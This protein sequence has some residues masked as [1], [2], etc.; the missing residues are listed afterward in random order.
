MN[1]CKLLLFLRVAALCSADRKPKYYDD[2]VESFPSL[3][4]KCIAITGTSTGLGYW[5]AVATAKK[6]PACLIMLNRPSKNAD[7]VQ[8]ELTKAAPN[9]T[10]ITVHFD[11]ASFASVRHAADRVNEVAK[12][13]SGLDV[14]AINAG[15]MMQP[16]V[17][18]G[19]GFDV[20][21][22]VNHLG[23]F[24][25][26]KLLMPSFH[27]AVEAGREVRHVTHTSAFRGS[28]AVG[29]KPFNLTYYE[30]LAP[31]TFG[32]NATHADLERY[33]QSKLANMLF[34]LQLYSKFSLD[35]RYSKFKALSAAP[36]F[37]TGT[38]LTIPEP[39]KT[40]M[41]HFALTPQDG[42]CSLLTAMFAPTA[43]SGDFY[44]PADAVI[45]PPYKFMSKGVASYSSF[46]RHLLGLD[47]KY[48]DQTKALM[49]SASE[50]AMGE[51]FVI[52]EPSPILV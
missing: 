44:E 48:D 47:D 51:K 50:K 11:L 23:H 35:A 28:F 33:H 6:D 14:F 16:D 40:L 7:A 17:R 20:T 15:T 13:Y 29:F 12:K 36:G 43:E 39:A 27:L 9:T 37:S 8:Q 45:G 38:S 18:T 10:V 26:T 22:E 42:C 41:E 1:F 52:P 49:W 31:G 30:K 4:G 3:Q 24:L 2:L 32:G 19:D 46:F 21:M 34:A 25:L 5:T